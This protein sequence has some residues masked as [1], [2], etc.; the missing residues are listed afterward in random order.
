MTDKEV[1]FYFQLAVLHGIDSV[2][3][4]DEIVYEGLVY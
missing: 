3:Y 2:H 1:E 4:A